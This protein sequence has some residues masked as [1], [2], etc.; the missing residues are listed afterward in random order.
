MGIQNYT[1][2]IYVLNCHNVV[3]LCKFGA[4]CTVVPNTATASA[5]AVEIKMAT[6]TG[7]EHAHCVFSFRNTKSKEIS[8]SV[9]QGTSQ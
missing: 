7:A 1:G 4:H 2:D 6:F 9:S 8:H 3:K 5:S